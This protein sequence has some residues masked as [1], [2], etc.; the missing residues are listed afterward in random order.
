MPQA[1][2]NTT[3]LLQDSPKNRRVCSR[4]TRP[5]S[6]GAGSV[7]PSGAAQA[8]TT[9]SSSV[10]GTQENFQRCGLV[11]R[12]RPRCVLQVPPDNKANLRSSKHF[13]AVYAHM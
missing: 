3:K 11:T 6:I 5:P 2:E 10:K 9:A 8:P 4:L 7:L 12:P 1:C 13:G